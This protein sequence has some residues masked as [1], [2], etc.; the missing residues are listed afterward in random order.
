MPCPRDVT[1]TLSSSSWLWVVFAL[2]HSWPSE[3]RTSEYSGSSPSKC[4]LYFVWGHPQAGA[5]TH[6]IPSPTCILFYIKHINWWVLIWSYSKTVK[7]CKY[8]SIS[9]CYDEF[10]W[11][12][13]K[14]LTKFSSK[15]SKIVT[16]LYSMHHSSLV[17]LL[18]SSIMEQK[19]P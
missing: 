14:R 16:I 8:N 4:L 7:V 19:Q 3:T 2:S 15:E 18:Y 5:W 9:K 1:A 6:D 13:D 10:P 12:L 11:R 17:S